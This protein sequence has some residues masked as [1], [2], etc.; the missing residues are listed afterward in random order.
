MFLLFVYRKKKTVSLC[1]LFQVQN[2]AKSLGI[3]MGEVIMTTEEEH[4][5]DLEKDS[6]V[7]DVLESSEGGEVDVGESTEEEEEE[8]ELEDI[9]KLVK[10]ECSPKRPTD[11]ADISESEEESVEKETVGTQN[12][13]ENIESDQNDF[14]MRDSAEDEEDHSVIEASKTPEENPKDKEIELEGMAEVGES[15]ENSKNNETD[16]DDSERSQENEDSTT[17][18]NAEKI[19]QLKVEVNE[20]IEKPSL[21][22]SEEQEQVELNRSSQV[23]GCPCPLCDY[24]PSAPAKLKEHL[25]QK[26]YAENIKADYMKD[27]RQCPIE[28]CEKEFANSGSL[29]RHIG[30]THGKVR[31]FEIITIFITLPQ[32]VDILREQGIEVPEY[33]CPRDGK[34]KKLEVATKDER[35]DIAEDLGHLTEDLGHSAETLEEEDDD[36]VPSYDGS[37]VDAAEELDEYIPQNK[38]VQVEDNEV[39]SLD[40]TEVS[41]LDRLDRLDILEKLDRQDK[42]DVTLNSY[43]TKQEDESLQE[44]VENDGL[45]C[46]LCDLNP[47][48]PA[49]LREHM[50]YKHF[51]ENIKAKFMKDER[52]CSVEECP[53]E[54]TNMSSLVRHIGS[55][56]NKVGKKAL[57][58]PVSFLWNT[59]YLE[60]FPGG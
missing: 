20:E 22:A 26:H 6:T 21:Q 28:D 17:I 42:L 29:V 15:T 11:E 50:A 27:D 1:N 32:V 47:N 25:A 9:E 10:E 59:C 49:K 53:K 30:S 4:S 36:C 38:E 44:G 13:Q 43:D 57:K 39:E 45:A 60:I 40:E 2:A 18:S 33:L 54:F 37:N 23:T 24:N 5:M 34:G 56:H 31:I 8:E 16:D 55:T 12:A 41:K 46:P 48:T 51:T 14:E 19:E 52:R 3:K 35:V 7:G 58:I